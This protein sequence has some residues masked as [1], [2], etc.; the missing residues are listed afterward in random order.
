MLA[1][2][3]DD[4]KSF[5]T[6]LFSREL[7]DKYYVTDIEIST[8]NT[9]SINGLINKSYYEDGES[10]S[11]SYWKDLK[12]LCFDLIKG[13]RLPVSFK[14]VLKLDEYNIEKFIEENSLDI[15]KDKLKEC[16]INIIYEDKA[17]TLTNGIFLND[18]ILDKGAQSAWDKY[19]LDILDKANISYINN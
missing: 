10:K 7:F 16:F 2:K 19:I 14:I 18:F 11:Y 13:K 1:I 12:P 8:Y 15:F 5:T 9:F 6:E 4:L 17:L 3:V